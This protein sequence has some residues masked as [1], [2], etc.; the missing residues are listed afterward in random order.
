MRRGRYLCYDESFFRH[1]PANHR[2]RATEHELW[3]FGIAD[4]SYTPSKIYLEL[5]EDRSLTR[6]YQS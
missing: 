5:V 2:G 3:V 6:Y 4:T 1:K